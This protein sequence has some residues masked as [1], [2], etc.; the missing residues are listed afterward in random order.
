MKKPVDGLMDERASYVALF[1][2][3]ALEKLYMVEPVTLDQL[4][5]KPNAD[6]AAT[7]DFLQ[8]LDKATVAAFLK[9]PSTFTAV[10]VRSSPHRDDSGDEDGSHGPGNCH[11]SGQTSTGS[12]AG[13]CSKTATA[14]G[15]ST[16]K[17]AFLAPNCRNNC[18]YNA[19]V[20]CTLAAFDGQ[21]LPSP[22]SSTPLA[23]VFFSAV[24]V[25]RA[26]INNYGGLPTA[27]LVSC[28]FPSMP[29]LRAQPTKH[30]L[31]SSSTTYHS[32]FPSIVLF[33][34]Y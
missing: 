27:V 5:H 22:D 34:P 2:A 23:N 19:A 33:A 32:S 30:R 31:S 20:A 21:P 12:G 7:L 28:N 29:H 10:T 26:N 6:I 25:V 3:T 24:E 9:N 17:P 1:R 11:G 4:R 8:R 13:R 18:F 16:P 15:P 14:N